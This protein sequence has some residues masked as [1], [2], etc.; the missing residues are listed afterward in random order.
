MARADCFSYKM[1]KSMELV[2]LKKHTEQK[3][4]ILQIQNFIFFLKTSWY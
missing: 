2:D 3:K 4:Q 1:I